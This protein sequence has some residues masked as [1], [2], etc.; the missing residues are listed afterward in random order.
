MKRDCEQKLYYYFCRLPEL[1]PPIRIHF[2][3][4]EK[5]KRRDLDNISSAGRKFILD[6]LQKCGKLKNDNLNYV[7][8]FSDEFEIGSDNAIIIEIE[9]DC[10][11]K[12]GE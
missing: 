8:G 9:E 7:V 12:N 2:T 3:W 4:I 1:K 5:N 6:T 10:K 11:N